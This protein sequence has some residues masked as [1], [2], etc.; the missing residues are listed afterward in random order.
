EARRIVLGRLPEVEALRGLLGE[1]G[2]REGA[3]G[4]AE[5]DLDVDDVLH[6]LAP[7]VGEDRAMTERA[8][9]PLEPAV[10]PADDLAA[11]QRLHR[12]VQGALVVVEPAEAPA[13]IAQRIGDGALA[14]GLAPRGVIHDEP[15][16]PAQEHVVGI[17]RGAEGAAGVARRRLHVDLLER[18]RAE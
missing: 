18:R 7:W 14:V 10:V 15:A 16:R 8:W 17:E 4:L 12:L 11:L 5:L 6:V 2:R 3:E 9:S 13:P 1:H